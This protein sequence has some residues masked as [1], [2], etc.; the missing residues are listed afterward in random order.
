PYFYTDH[1]GTPVEMIGTTLLGIAYV[2][3]PD[4]ANFI[5]TYLGH[6]EYFLDLAHGVITLVS[7]LCASY[8]FLTVLRA[9]QKPNVYLAFSLALLFYGLHPSSFKTLTFWSHSS[10]SF[11]LG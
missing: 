3:F 7:V 8:F 1:P 4:P 6:P 2:F 9:F 5:H 11:P 10:F